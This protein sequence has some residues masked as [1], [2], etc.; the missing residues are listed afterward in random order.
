MV[1]DLA[2]FVEVC[3]VQA[4]STLS[5]VGSAL[6]ELRA[7][8]ETFDI[9]CKAAHSS[10]E[11]LIDVS[12][13]LLRRPLD[14]EG[15][16]AQCFDVL[17]SWFSQGSEEPEFLGRWECEVTLGLIDR[18]GKL[19]EASELLPCLTMWLNKV[20][21]A[22][23]QDLTWTTITLT[24]NCQGPGFE[25]G[26]EDPEKEVWM[27]ALGTFQGGGLWI[28]DQGGE[29]PVVRVRRDGSALS[30]E[31]RS[32]RGLPVRF[33]GVRKYG[34]EPWMGG[35]LWVIKAFTM[36]GCERLS[37]ESAGCLERWG[38]G[39]VDR[40]G[41]RPLE[42]S[43]GGV[44]GRFSKELLAWEVD[45]PH[46]ILKESERQN[47]VSLHEAAL[48]Q[49]RRLR[50]SMS[51][52]E[53]DLDGLV[54]TSES[55]GVAGLSCCWLEAVLELY[56]PEGVA[57]LKSLAKEVPLREPDPNPA[58]IFLQTRTVS[59]EE[60]RLELELW[61][62]PAEEEVQA[63]E[64]TTK[65]VERVN[66]DV[67][68]SWVKEGRKVIQ[69]PGKAV[70]T[71]KAGVGKRRF[72][73]VC[74]GNHIPTSQVADKKSDLYA[75]GI[76]SLT[77]R[78]V[79]A[80]SAQRKEWEACVVDVKTAFLYAPVRGSSEGDPEP[81]IIVV[82][83]PYL[84]VQLGV[85]KTTDR[86]RVQRALYGLQTSPRD[87][88][89][90][91]DRE[92]RA[93]RIGSP[94]EAR[95]QQGVTDDSL[96]LVKN[97]EGVTVAL[98]IVYV[99]DIGLFGPRLILEALVGELS[100]KWKLSEP[101]WARDGEQVSFCGMELARMSYGWRVTQKRYLQEL[102]QRYG[103]TGFASAPLTKWEEPAEEEPD[104]EAVRRAQGITGALLWA[105]T[106][107]RP[108]MAFV[109]SLM[110]QLSTKTPTKVYDMGVQA[111]KYASSTLDLGLEYKCIEG[112]SFGLEG[113]LS[114]SRSSNA[115]EVYS[116]ASHSPNGERSR[117][118]VV[119]VWK[120]SALL[121][122]A[123]KQSFT[124]LSTAESE[125]VGMTHAAQVGECVA[126]IIEELVEDDVVISLL[127]DNAAALSA[128]EHAGGS[129]RSRHLRMRAN[130]GRE[131]VA[132]GSLFPCYVPGHLQVAD[133]GTKP[134]PVGKLLGLLAII[135]VGLPRE[136]TAGTYA[137]SFSPEWA[138]L[139]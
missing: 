6:S 4:G 54:R 57:V 107:S 32:I 3:E 87:W 31:V 106:R 13:E 105:V 37:E 52:G 5:G 10:L 81:T 98:M 68:E 126:P 85:L 118:C 86:W 49:Q 65:A 73:A 125:L 91:R 78:V 55:I 40:V 44:T 139:I 114:H 138:S 133:I 51:E 63:L 96:W 137:L 101:S 136:G 12:E 90:Y 29:G 74:C 119:V 1:C 94:V 131:R 70:L 132:A 79:L 38:F 16:D 7:C 111:L 135:N 80:F 120:G 15:L 108:D 36:R 67:V 28:E 61:K 25:D 102:L 60:A 66:A 26:F 59:L 76:D 93:I 124:T 30:G 69:V 34:L 27:V 104:A 129:W 43:S 112:P 14:G 95:L 62:T 121:W 23:C 75:G 18:E 115:L 8:E 89:T 72:R 77:V 39:R 117:Q 20:I 88:A 19:S 123:T 56:G 116:D 71:R 92:L 127:G 100:K 53:L 110:A 17:Q 9:A 82:K 47:A 48:Y 128:Y 99:D 97:K 21:R 2:N 113:Q 58:E 50:I 42:S 41:D 83:P 35:D 103:I 22:W 46:L 130:A 109:V 11:G 45:F 134:L 33:S 24:R 84:L 64:D 122:E